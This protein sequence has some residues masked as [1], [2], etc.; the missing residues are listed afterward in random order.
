MLKILSRLRKME[1]PQP[2]GSCSQPELAIIIPALNERENLEL[3]IPATWDVLSKLG[4]AAEVIVVD[5]GST[6][7]TS[8]VAQSRGARAVHQHERGY[9]GALLAGFAAT[10]AQYLITMDADLS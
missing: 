7:G 4:V 1:N 6:D 10:N 3:L 9:G 2:N 5:G 8:A